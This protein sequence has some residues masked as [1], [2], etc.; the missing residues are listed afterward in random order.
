MAPTSS[1]VLPVRWL[2][3]SRD[4][5]S[6]RCGAC[7]CCWGSRS[8]RSGRCCCSAGGASTAVAV[9]AVSAAAAASS[10]PAVSWSWIWGSADCLSLSDDGRFLDLA[11]WLTASEG[12]WDELSC[13]VN[14]WLRAWVNE[15]GACGGVGPRRGGRA[16][17]AVGGVANRRFARGYEAKGGSCQARP[18]DREASIG[19]SAESRAGYVFGSVRRGGTRESVVAK[20]AGPFSKPCEP[21]AG[22]RRPDQP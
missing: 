19:Y 21:H 16:G 7:C 3:S 22:K 18:D 8:R 20:R 5:R 17:R 9:A 13:R 14:A 15:C 12:K 1:P 4:S 6:A 11:M 2:P 10:A